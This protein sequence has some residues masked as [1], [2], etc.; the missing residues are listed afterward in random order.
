MWLLLDPA[1][2]AIAQLLDSVAP[3]VKKSSPG[4]QFSTLEMLRRAFS[5]P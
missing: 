5:I 2:V 4:R 3:E 1:A